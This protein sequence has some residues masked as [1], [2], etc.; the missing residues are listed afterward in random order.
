MRN[1][2]KIYVSKPEEKT[3]IGRLWECNI[4]GFPLYVQLMIPGVKVLI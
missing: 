3:S 4:M 1:A 2:Y